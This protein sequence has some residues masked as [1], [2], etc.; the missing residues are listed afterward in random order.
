MY[1]PRQIGI[2]AETRNNI[3]YEEYKPPAKLG[4]LLF[5][6]WELRTR[7]TLNEDFLY[8]I[9]PDA[10]SDIIFD[11]R[12]AG[13]DE[14]VFRMTSGGAVEKI[15]LGRQFHFAGLRFLPGVVRDNA[16]VDK[17]QLQR[18]WQRLRLAASVQ[19]IQAELISF[20]SSLLAEGKI[21]ENYLMYHILSRSDHLRRVEDIEHLSGY[22]RRQLQRIFKAQTG[23]TPREF[24]R[25]L[26]FQR[27]IINNPDSL[28]ADQSHLIKEFK[29]ITGLT[30]KMFKAKY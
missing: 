20:A 19:E 13:Q 7:S 29:R 16:L 30:P 18:A 26:R 4:K 22:T 24:L 14:R 2:P 3:V 17:R 27:A 9:L 6:T 23:L 5:Y 25:V 15:N 1:T 12:A 28:Y 11:L 8:L 10:C 21:A